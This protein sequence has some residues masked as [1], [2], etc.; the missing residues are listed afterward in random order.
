MRLLRQVFLGAAVLVCV[1][2]FV[3]WRIDSPRVDRVRMAL[4]DA[5]APGL[6]WT[7]APLAGISRMVEDFESYTRVYEQNE[8]LRRELQRMQGWRE[9]ALQL[10]QENA[11]L[12]A[13]NKVHASPRLNFATGE[14]LADSG[15]PYSQSA[16]IN[17]GA[18]DGVID[19]SA[20]VDGIIDGSAR[21]AGLGLVGRVAGVGNRT[22]RIILLTDAS[23]RLPVVLR[24]SGL[25]AILSG[26]NTA[27][28]RLEFLEAADAIDPGDRVVT[29]GDGGVLPPDLLVGEV[30]L[31][32][33]GSLKVRLAADYRR[34]EFVRVL[35]PPPS[36]DVTGPGGLI[37][38]DARFTD[39]P[40]ANPPPANPPLANPPPANPPLAKPPL[41]DAPAA[42]AP[43][44]DRTLRDNQ[45]PQDPPAQSPLSAD[46][47][48]E[49]TPRRDAPRPSA[50]DLAGEA[51]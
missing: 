51:G 4:V 23:S 13:L 1:L 19:G 26:D 47:N 39:A 30:V 5:I 41:A 8:A 38:P 10:E 40:P 7:A 32:P 24:P 25:R 11:R 2:A 17:I 34:L 21:A 12:R 27:M 20:V 16:L 50:S 22:A 37:L 14:I 33:G 48:A 31:G 46:P 36:P 49:S 9:A 45:G 6:E 3:L 18:R 29:S 44:A 43:P 28:P 15:G 42:D 35:Q